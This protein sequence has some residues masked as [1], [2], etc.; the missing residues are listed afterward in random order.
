MRIANKMKC[1]N[2]GRSNIKTVP[3]NMTIGRGSYFGSGCTFV[4]RNGGR[5]RIGNFC[6]IA[7]GVSIINVN[8]NYKTV[9][10]YPFSVLHC[11][12]K[13]SRDRIVSDVIIENDVWVGKNAII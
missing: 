8:H 13:E 10:T 3:E 2:P 7:N 1:L 4:A 9:S 6:S 11:K 5:I 12:N